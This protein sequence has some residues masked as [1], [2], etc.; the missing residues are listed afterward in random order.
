MAKVVA[1]TTNKAHAMFGNPFTRLW[2]VINTSQLLSH[3]FPKYLKLTEIVMTH[4]LD[5]LKINDVL[6]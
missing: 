4:I 2:C 1:L 3:T 5:L 6:I